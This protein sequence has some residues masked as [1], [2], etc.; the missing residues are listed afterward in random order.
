MSEE[1]R[2]ISA[3]ANSEKKRPEMFEF[4]FKCDEFQRFAQIANAKFKFTKN[5]GL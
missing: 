5:G 2:Q 4:L 3:A 1:I